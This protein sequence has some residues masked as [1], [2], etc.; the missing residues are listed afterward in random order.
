MSSYGDENPFIFK[1]VK[2]V[3]CTRHSIVMGIV[4]LKTKRETRKQQ[5]LMWRQPHK[6]NRLET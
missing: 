2:G 4:I 5:G 3:V 1:N 6:K